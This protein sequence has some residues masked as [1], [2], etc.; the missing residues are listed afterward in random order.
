MARSSKWNCSPKYAPKSFK[1][2]F[3]IDSNS[4]Q[5]INTSFKGIR[6]ILY[7]FLHLIL[8][9]IWF[10][11]LINWNSLEK[12]AIFLSAKDTFNLNTIFLASSGS[13]SGIDIQ[14]SLF[15]LFLK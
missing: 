14:T 8:S 2:N 15:S 5:F 7:V 4:Q 6:T 12:I 9:E 13:T 3:L 10:E 1:R 11:S